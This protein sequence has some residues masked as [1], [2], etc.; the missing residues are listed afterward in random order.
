[1]TNDQPIYDE[2]TGIGGSYTRDPVTGKRVPN[3]PN[4]AAIA[5]SEVLASLYAQRAD[6][7]TPTHVVE[8]GDA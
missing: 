4:A 1:M 8:S 6:A 2:H 7:P 3:T 5:D